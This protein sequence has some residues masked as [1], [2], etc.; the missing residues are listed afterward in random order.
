MGCAASKDEVEAPDAT[1]KEVKPQEVPV[2]IVNDAKPPSKKASSATIP[3]P[4]KKAS[5]AAIPPPA[6]KPSAEATVPLPKKEE[7]KPKAAAAAAGGES[8]ADKQKAIAMAMQQRQGGPGGGMYGGGKPPGAGGGMYGGGKP[9]AGG[10]GDIMRGSM[11]KQPSAASGQLF[12]AELGGSGKGKQPEPKPT[13][14]DEYATLSRPKAPKQR[15]PKSTI[16]KSAAAAE[17][18]GIQDRL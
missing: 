12:S 17:V 15:R 18:E 13:G 14:A 1:V 6:K 8:F 3:P 5:S 7:E 16:A 10:I 11:P 4:A 2:A 9:P